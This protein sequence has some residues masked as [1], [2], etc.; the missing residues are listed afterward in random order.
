MTLPFGGVYAC[1][2]SQGR[3]KG[4]I[5]IIASIIIIIIEISISII[6][7]TVATD[8]AIY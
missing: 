1:P 5:L 6:T 7:F 3:E 2:K 8:K 4:H